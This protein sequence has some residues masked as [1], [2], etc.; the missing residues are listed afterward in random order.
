MPR[1]T[2]RIRIRYRILKI[3]ALCCDAAAARGQ[4]RRDKAER[5]KEV[6]PEDSQ[7]SSGSRIFAIVSSAACRRSSISASMARSC[8]SSRFAA[9]L[10]P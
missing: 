1:M 7:A 10:A 4:E 6:A 3:R 2:L 8:S 9:R 5:M